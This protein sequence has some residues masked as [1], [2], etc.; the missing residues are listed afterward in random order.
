MLEAKPIWNSFC[1]TLREV[2][3]P[4]KCALCDQ[5]GEPP[6]CPVCASE[7]QPH[8]KVRTYLQGPLA[9]SVT[10]YDYVGRA[11]QAVRRLKY[12]RVTSLA[13]PMAEILREA[14]DRDGLEVFDVV[15]PIPIHWSRLAGRG[16]NQS[17]LLSGRLLRVEPS[18]LRRTRRTRPQVG[19]TRARRETNL[20]G[21][22]RVDRSVTGMRVLLVDDVVTSGSTARECA[23]VL[24]DAGATE[25]AVLAFAG[26]GSA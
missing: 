12:E 22:F 8:A 2:I 18:V 24:R 14:Y 6:I 3:W 20:R 9:F 11:G 26:E 23:R 10:P 4:P 19:L 21:A 7:L 25:V 13:E 5:F 16:F 17:D 1:S 15:V